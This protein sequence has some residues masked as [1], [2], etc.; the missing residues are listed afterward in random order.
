MHYTDGTHTDEPPFSSPP[1]GFCALPL[2]KWQCAHDYVHVNTEHIQRVTEDASKSHC[3]LTLGSTLRHP[4]T[5]RIALSLEEVSRRLAEV[6][7][8]R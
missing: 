2:A 8:P 3:T 1:A 7:L 6:C 5:I 4:V